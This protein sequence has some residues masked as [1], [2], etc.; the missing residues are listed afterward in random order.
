MYIMDHRIEC[1]YRTEHILLQQS[2]EKAKVMPSWCIMP[3]YLLSFRNQNI[4]KMLG[5]G[6]FSV[7]LVRQWDRSY[8]FISLSFFL[9]C[10][11]CD[12]WKFVMW[13]Q[14]IWFGLKA[15]SH[16]RNNT[17]SGVKWVLII[18]FGQLQMFTTTT[19]ICLFINLLI[20]LFIISVTF[21]ELW[22]W[23]YSLKWKFIKQQI[24]ENVSFFQ[25]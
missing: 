4:E 9:A 12:K 3:M 20:Y 19:V 6:E 16:E 25:S 8:R 11:Y 17:F 15:P 18:K 5:L 23:Q 10:A 21:N 22:K 24:G 7:A 13:K 14:L 2:E 1:I